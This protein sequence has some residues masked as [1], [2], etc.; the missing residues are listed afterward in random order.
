M[1][2]EELSEENDDNIEYYL[3]SYILLNKYIN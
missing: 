2:E 1:Y 3:K